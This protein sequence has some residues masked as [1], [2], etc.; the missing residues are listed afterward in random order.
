M[1]CVACEMP[2]KRYQARTKVNT[3]QWALSCAFTFSSPYLM[4]GRD[5]PMQD[6]CV[7]G[8]QYLSSSR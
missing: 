8:I 7:G 3:I 2:T 6:I 1:Q 5:V 4:S